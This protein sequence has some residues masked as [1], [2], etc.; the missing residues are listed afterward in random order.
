MFVR[1]VLIQYILVAHATGRY[2]SK[3]C[4][5]CIK[6]QR[7]LIGTT[8]VVGLWE[9]GFNVP[10][11]QKSFEVRCEASRLSFPFYS[12]TFAE[13]DGGRMEKEKKKSVSGNKL[14]VIIR[15]GSSLL[16]TDSH[17]QTC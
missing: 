6:A 3:I 8:A 13:G 5:K 11:V 12:L 10:K 17:T 16:R 2:F 9:T 1:T 14:D 4:M 7:I 15:C